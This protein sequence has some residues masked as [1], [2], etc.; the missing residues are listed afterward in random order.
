MARFDPTGYRGEHAQHF[1][2]GGEAAEEGE[3]DSSESVK[4]MFVVGGI[5]F[6]SPAGS[7]SFHQDP[8]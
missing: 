7:T 4:M 3:A 6:F 5:K 1:P 2:V 8:L